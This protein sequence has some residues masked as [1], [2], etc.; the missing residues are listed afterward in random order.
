[1][2]KV[3]AEIGINFAFGDDK[4]KFLDNAKRLIDSAV[5]AGCDFVKF[6]KR[7]PDKCVPDEQKNKEKTVPWR[8]TPTT[9]LQ[10]KKDIEFGRR[11][12]N[13]I[14]K[15]CKEK[16]IGW[17]A[18]VWDLDSVDFMKTYTS[19]RTMS[20]ISK[21]FDGDSSAV[22]MKIPSALITNEELCRYARK[23]C[24][25]L[26]ISTGMST[27]EEVDKAFKDCIPNLMFHTN[28]SYPS[29]IEELNLNYIKHLQ[30]SFSCDIGYSGHE[31]GIT[32]TMATIM[33]GVRWIER[34]ITL[35]RTL[36][37]SDQ[38]ASVET[39]GFIKLVKGI[40]DIELAT[41]YEEAPRQLFESELSK[42]KSLRGD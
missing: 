36:W 8:D 1:M 11:E 29:P 6:Q 7:N 20:E 17:F 3:I 16:G 5:L 34:H 35:D 40:R 39:I 32:T 13:A 37:G 14:D 30:N 22:I 9:Y 15:Y 24:D 10:Y 25:Y 41:Q 19:G 42:R 26:M 2:T 18:S 27:Q 12:Y 4:S 31:F 28:S 38:F 33:L 23:N 21:Y